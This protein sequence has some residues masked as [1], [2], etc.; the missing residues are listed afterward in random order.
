MVE[1]GYHSWTF[2]LFEKTGILSLGSKLSEMRSKVMKKLELSKLKREEVERKLKEVEA[3]QDDTVENLKDTI[4]EINADGECR[5]ILIPEMKITLIT[6]WQQGVFYRFDNSTDYYTRK[7]FEMGAKQWEEATCVDFK[8]DKDKK[9]NDSIV[10][11]KEDGCWS[12]VGRVGGE[13]PLSLGNGCDQK[14][15]AAAGCG[16][17][18]KAKESKQFLIDKLGFPSGVR[19]EFMFCNYWIEAPE[20]KKVEI[21]INSI[22]HGYAH[23]GCILGGVEIKSSKDQ[24][25]TGYRFCSPN[26]RNT[27]LVSASN[28]VPVIT[29]NRSGQQQIILEYKIVS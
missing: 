3:R 13:Q 7:M 20:G 10:L 23:D 16:K 4:Y 28:R 6:T 22:S 17:I 27:V 15:F 19:D 26:D 5:Q 9:A 29:F 8:E 24:I 14:I 11:I 2:Q 12:Y 21:K 1:N 25:P 18:L